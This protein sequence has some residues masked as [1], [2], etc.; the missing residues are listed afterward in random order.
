MKEEFVKVYNEELAALRKYGA[1]FAETHPK[2]AGRLKLGQGNVED[3]LVGRLLESFSFL[4]ARSQYQLQDEVQKLD[5][6]LIQL[7]YP[8]YFL[9]IP[10]C[11][12]VQLH[13]SE[14]LDRSYLAA[15]KT[16]LSS[17]MG[18]GKL[19]V[20]T[21]VYP[22]TVRPLQLNQINYRREALI[23][24]GQSKGFKSCLSMTLSVNKK[25]QALKNFNLDS[26]RIFI[27]SNSEIAGLLYELIFSN[28]R[29]IKLS[30]GSHHISFP[31]KNLQPVG[32]EESETLLPYPKNSF[33]GYRLL[34][35]YFSYPEKFLFFDLNQLNDF[36]YDEATDKVQ[37]NFYFDQYYSDLEKQIENTSFL[38]NCTPVVNLFEK[39]AESIQVAPEEGKYHVVPDAAY[40]QANMEVYDITDLSISSIENRDKI[41]CAPYF[42]RKFK[43]AN[44]SLL[45]WH[46]SR[47]SSDS[48]G[49]TQI[50][51]YETFLNISN[52]NLEDQSTPLAVTTKLLCT[53][54]NAP[55]NL[56]FGGGKPDWIFDE[57][58]QALIK[59]V[60]CVKTITASKYR[61][62]HQ[63]NRLQLAKHLYLNQIGYS[64]PNNTL[65]TL[66]TA[67]MIYSFGQDY[68]DKLIESGIIEARAEA[69]TIR[70][71]DPLR[72]GFCRGI[73]Y[74]IT[75]DESCFID[76]DM[77]L[78][79][80][81]LSHFLTKSCS[82]NSFVS[83]DL[84]SKQRGELFK[85]PVRLGIKPIL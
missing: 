80:S 4:T 2:I 55:R 49:A 36:I 84:A 63:H 35:E 65:D 13:P 6:N 44:E 79:G 8:H 21:T 69:I 26:L 24:N 9:P 11:S 57:G 31:I 77:Y 10:S 23:Q 53:N 39:S 81:I 67:L 33:S 30:Y 43:Q 62:D 34:T 78:L 85:W 5:E 1:I 28:T 52:F 83:L 41:D 61:A 17:S 42:G 56:P 19:I 74:K 40:D 76:R 72:Q 12:T 51:G 45:Y 58:K 75:V 70:H 7:L 59:S 27:N 32:F 73:H 82:I 50:P 71:P 25:N 47:K 3:P 48:L 38:L 22:V 68:Q 18:E 66:K 16:S 64:D 14:G 15:K 46:L 60:R 20:F 54:R 29:E 37:I